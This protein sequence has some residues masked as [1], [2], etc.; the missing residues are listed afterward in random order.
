[1]SFFRFLLGEVPPAAPGKLIE[2]ARV[3]NKLVASF[4]SKTSSDS[5]TKEV[6]LHRLALARSRPATD[7][8]MLMLILTARQAVH[9]LQTYDLAVLDEGRRNYWCGELNDALV[10]IQVLLEDSVDS[11]LTELGFTIEN[12]ATALN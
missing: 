5:E 6:F 7:L 10:G 9:V 8:D 12:G 3:V 11:T 1:M 2:L 4:S